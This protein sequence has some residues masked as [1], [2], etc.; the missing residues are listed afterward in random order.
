MPDLDYKIVSGEE[1]EDKYGEGT[2]DLCND[3]EHLIE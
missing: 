3:H 2:D 1:L